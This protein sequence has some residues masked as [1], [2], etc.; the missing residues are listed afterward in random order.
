M[1]EIR[2]LYLLAWDQDERDET[3]LSHSQRNFND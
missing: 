3:P 2:A 1:L